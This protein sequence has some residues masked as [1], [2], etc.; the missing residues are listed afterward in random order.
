MKVVIDTNV[1]LAIIPRKSKYHYILEK[2]INKE[3]EI[4]LSNE[5]LLEYYEVISKKTNQEIADNITNLLLSLRSSI[6]ITPYYFWTLIENDATDNKFADCAI[7]GGADF[8]VTEDHHFNILKKISF[9]K[10]EVISLEK[11]YTIL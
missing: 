2:L 8:I 1:L 10:I 7:T 9:P 4:L 5:I 11:F 3:F 6:L